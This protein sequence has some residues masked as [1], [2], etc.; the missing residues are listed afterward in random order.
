MVK[1][2]IIIVIIAII[3]ISTPAATANTI[4]ARETISTSVPITESEGN[5]AK[6]MLM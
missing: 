5:A 2:I 6:M 3:I 4:I 1:F